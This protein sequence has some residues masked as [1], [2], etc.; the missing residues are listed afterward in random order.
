MTTAINTQDI[1]LGLALG[2]VKLA[3]TL[4]RPLDKNTQE[5]LNTCEKLIQDAAVEQERE[6]RVQQALS[7]AFHPDPQV[8]RYNRLER[9]A[10]GATGTELEELNAELDRLADSI[11]CRKYDC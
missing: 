6:H 10:E 9:R 2:L 8:R 5:M 11:Y 7:A 3:D 4:A 1:D